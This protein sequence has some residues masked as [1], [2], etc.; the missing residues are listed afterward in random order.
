MKKA[1]YHGNYLMGYI[2]AITMEI[3]V[4]TDFNR[5][6]IQSFINLGTFDTRAVYDDEGRLLH[7]NI[8]YVGKQI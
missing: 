1:L 6:L 3:E 7:Y 4:D 2:D 5:S 8:V